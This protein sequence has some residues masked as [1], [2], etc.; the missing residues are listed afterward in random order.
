M[1][2]LLKGYIIFEITECHFWTRLVMSQDKKAKLSHA[3]C[4]YIYIYI[5]SLIIIWYKKGHKALAGMVCAFYTKIKSVRCKTRWRCAQENVDMN[6]SL[7][8]E[9]LLETPITVVHCSSNIIYP[10][11]FYL[12]P[13]VIC[14]QWLCRTG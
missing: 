12:S 1:C 13:S 9:V 3:K 2:S 11:F 5:I 14:S 8:E 6:L 7:K 4:L 10:L